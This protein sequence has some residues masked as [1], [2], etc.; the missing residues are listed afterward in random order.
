ML[1]EAECLPL[2]DWGVWGQSWT[3]LCVSWTVLHQDT[4]PAQALGFHVV[5]WNPFS[6][7]CLVSLLTI[8]TQPHPGQKSGNH[9][10]FCDFVTL[11]SEGKVTQSCL[12]LCDPMEFSWPAYWSGLPFPSPKDLPNPGID[13]RS[14]TLQADSLP[15]EPPG[16]P[17]SS[18][19]FPNSSPF[20]PP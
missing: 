8:F 5:K 4:T 7:P 14:P 12:T 19:D 20:S 1:R 2:R 9:P 10:C 6:V 18:K 15:A 3:S 17:Y 16:K 11:L 13:P